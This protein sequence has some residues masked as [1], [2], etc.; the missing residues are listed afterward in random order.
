MFNGLQALL[1][2]GWGGTLDIMYALMYLEM[3]M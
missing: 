2:A 1:A 3:F